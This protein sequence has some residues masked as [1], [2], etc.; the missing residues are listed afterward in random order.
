MRLTPY[1]AALV[2]SERLDI[3]TDMVKPT[4]RLGRGEETISTFLTL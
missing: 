1:E 4:G 3:H 2:L